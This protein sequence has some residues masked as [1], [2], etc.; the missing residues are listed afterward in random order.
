MST[1]CLGASTAGGCDI[2][3]GE[4]GER[5]LSVACMHCSDAPCMRSARSTASSRRPTAWSCTTRTSASAAATLLRRPFGAP[6]F[7]TAGCSARA[8][9]GQ[10]HLLRRGPAR[11][12]AP[13]RCASTAQ[14]PRRGQAAAVR[15]DVRQPRRSGGDG[16]VAD[17]FRS[18]WRTA[19]P[20]GSHGW[21]VAYDK[22][23]RKASGLDAGSG[24][25]TDGT[26]G[27]RP[28]DRERRPGAA[29]AAPGPNIAPITG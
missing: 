22:G 24:R 2:N 13:S 5:S 1:R 3:D 26:A 29:G 15:G 17:I 8:Q 25:R 6:Q 27:R 16:R 9:D 21:G 10:V 23:M 28:A 11:P 20:R 12:T 18:A 14:P 4:K 7:P 19:A